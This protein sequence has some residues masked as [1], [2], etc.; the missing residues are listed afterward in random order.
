MFLTFAI[1]GGARR[2]F[3]FVGKK[4]GAELIRF[5]DGLSTTACHLERGRFLLCFHF[6]IQPLC[7]VVLKAKAKR[8]VMIARKGI[9]KIVYKNHFPLSKSLRRHTLQHLSRCLRA[10]ARFSGACPGISSPIALCV[11][12]TRVRRCA[13]R[14]FFV[15]YLHKWSHL[16]TSL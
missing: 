9:Y 11:E 4:L 8:T 16:C 1:R 5:Q 13:A 7:L 15:Y 6:Q 3:A 12:S 2:G 14:S 10:C